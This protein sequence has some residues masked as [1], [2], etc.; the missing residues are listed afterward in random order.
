MN[1]DLCANSPQQLLGATPALS[2]SSR[3]IMHARTHMHAHTRTH[4]PIQAL[5]FRPRSENGHSLLVS[6]G[7]PEIV[8]LRGGIHGASSTDKL[9]P[10]R[11][12]GWVRGSE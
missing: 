12:W 3:G 10:D 8:P 4:T 9:G 1:T 7:L 6:P 2:L 11:V 5:F